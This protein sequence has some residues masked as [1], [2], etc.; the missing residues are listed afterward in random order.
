[1]NFGDFLAL[2]FIF[3]IFSYMVYLVI[4]NVLDLFF[5]LQNK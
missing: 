1:M 4:H 2:L 3:F 5:R